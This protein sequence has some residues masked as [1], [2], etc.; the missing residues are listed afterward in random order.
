LGGML[1]GAAVGMWGEQVSSGAGEIAG[2][3]SGTARKRAAALKLANR[4]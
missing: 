4:G 1:H 2:G 3:G